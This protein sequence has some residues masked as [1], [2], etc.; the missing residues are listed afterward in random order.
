MVFEKPVCEECTREGKQRPGGR[1]L[2]DHHHELAIAGL[3]ATNTYPV[4]NAAR[5]GWFVR[6]EVECE[7]QIQESV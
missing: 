6:E 4:P 1:V 7:R 2:C 5:R 3:R